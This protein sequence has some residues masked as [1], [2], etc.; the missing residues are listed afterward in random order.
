[1]SLAPKMIMSLNPIMN[2]VKSMHDDID[3]LVLIWI[4]ASQMISQ[5]SRR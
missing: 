1:M 3:F 5:Y 4:G 2:I